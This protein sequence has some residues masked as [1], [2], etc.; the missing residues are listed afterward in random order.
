[1]Q[2]AAAAYHRGFAHGLMF[3]RFHASADANAW[4]GAI[5]PDAFDATLQFV[6]IENILSPGEW[7]ARLNQGQLEAQHL[8]ITFDDGLQSQLE[9]A[10]PVL[11]RYGIRAFWFVYSCVFNGLPVRGEIYSYVAGQMGG[12]EALIDAFLRQCPADMLQQ[13]ESDHYA[14]YA[15]RIRAIIPFYSE[16]D[17]QY[18]FLRNENGSRFETLMDT[19]LRE[20]GF[21]I[22]DIARRLWLTNSDLRALADAGHEIGLHSYDH[23]YEMARLSFDQQRQQY[24]RNRAHLAAVIGTSP[25]CMSHPLNSYN[26]DTLQVLK[27][28]GIRCGFRANVV[29]PPSK[30]VNATTLE[31]AREDAA[32]VLA[33]M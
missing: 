3:H 28:L 33:M 7:M 31:L 17:L 18:R 23:P 26:E 1:M 11:D 10:V 29:A 27:D 24:E 21:E 16:S 12:M 32:N 15:A 4:Q 22:D 6:G 13:L 30:R 25:R 19:L 14:A 9:H 8:C 20:R 2:K 5:T